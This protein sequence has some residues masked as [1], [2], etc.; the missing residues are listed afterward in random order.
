MPALTTHAQTLAADAEA[1]A[2]CADRL[3][4]L[5][6]RMRGQEAAP[7]W[8][9]ELLNSHLSACTVASAD[10]TT[11]AARMRAFAALSS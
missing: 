1:L 4:D 10:V 6:R 5:A 2:D 8:L 3:R 7:P 11:A 9:C